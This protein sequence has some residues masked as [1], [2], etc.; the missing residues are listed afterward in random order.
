[1]QNILKLFGVKD[2]ALFERRFNR[3]LIILT[4]IYSV[5]LGVILFISA[6]FSYSIFS[7]RVGAR[8]ERIPQMQ[9]M[10]I[11]IEIEI[12][13]SPTVNEVR[14]ELVEAFIRVNSALF[15]LAV[16]GSYFL[17]RITLRP[18]KEAY[19]DQ[20]RFIADA[21][22]ELRTPL[23]VM[24]I[25]LENDIAETRLKKHSTEKLESQLEE[26]KR[27]S[28]IVED[29]LYLSK[30]ESSQTVSQIQPNQISGI[31]KSTVKRLQTFAE[32]KKVQIVFEEKDANLEVKVNDQISHVF[33]NII[34]NGIL[35]NKDGGT[36]TISIQPKKNLVDIKIQDTGI[37]MGHIDLKHVFDR[38]YR[39]DKSRSRSVGGSGLGLAIA[40]QI[41]ESNN[42]TIYI[43]SELEK[44]TT[45]TISL[46]KA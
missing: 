16:I 22:H 29:L 41:I 45:V 12:R 7:S 23:S 15:I 11:P 24:H 6:T 31:I 37:G 1:M 36:V 27:M 32:S 3:S 20:R 26:V 14:E 35:Y 38:F 17:A 39:V 8:F 43:E 10:Q 18:L 46:P 34:K 44:G 9:Q 28:K 33:L 21:S 5:T 2:S 30:L 25:E 40:Q 42:G 4:L 13:K 19:E